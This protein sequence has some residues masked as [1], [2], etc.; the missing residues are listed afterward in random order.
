MDLGLSFAAY[1]P[2]SRRTIFYGHAYEDLGPALARQTSIHWGSMKN[3]KLVTI[4]GIFAVA[5]IAAVTPTAAMA[6][7]PA[8]GSAAILTNRTCNT[9]ANGDCQLGSRNYLQ[10]AG[11]AGSTFSTSATNEANS[12]A[13][14][15][16]Y[17]S[18]GAGT[19]PTLGVSSFAGSAT[20]PVRARWHIRRSRTPVMS[21]SISP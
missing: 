3:K 17:S 1:P 13:S 2:L 6:D 11:G 9:T 4:N 21:R 14:G 19:V 5:A 18:F 12:G 16:A 20:G 7:T 10:Y 15:S 8:Y